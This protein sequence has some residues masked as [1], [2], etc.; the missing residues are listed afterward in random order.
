MTLTA[1]DFMAGGGGSSQGIHNVPGLELTLVLNHWRLAIDTHALNFPAAQHECCDISQADFRWYPRVD[2]LWSSPEC[3]HHSVASGRKRVQLDQI[4]DENGEVLPMDAAE[5]SRATAWDVLRYLERMILRGR[6][7]LGGVVENV[8]DF[9]RWNLFEPWRK[10][11]ELLGYDTEVIHLNSAHAH[12]RKALWSPQS[13]D[14]FYLGYAH[15]SLG[16]KPDWEKWLRPHAT[17]PEHGAVRARQDF[18]R[19]DREPWGRYRTQYVYRCPEAGCGQI[20]EPLALPASRA[21]DWTI[22]A[23]RI[24]D[25][26]RPLAKKT[27]DRIRDGLERYARHLIVPVE[28]REGKQA[29]PLD[30][31]AR[32]MTTRRETGVAFRP[33]IAELRG[34]ASKHRSTTDPLCTVTASGNHH[35]LVTEDLAVPYYGTGRARPLSQPLG[36]LTTV[37]RYGLLKTQIEVEDCLFRMLEPEE[38]GTAMSFR[39]GYRLLGTKRERVRMLGNAVTPNSSEILVSAVVEAITGE[40]LE[41]APCPV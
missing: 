35:G 13:R 8:I 17:C 34:G 33:F 18:K 26:K 36:A 41:P 32:T 1:G 12:A 28:G 23:Q 14:R 11:F 6:P 2:V 15:R 31:P 24:G 7:V 22:P 27:M 38:I 5:R 16:R 20:I 37:D 29:R 4:P 3:T 25:R 10:G 21:I 39:E 9:Q 19:K 30:E 40:D